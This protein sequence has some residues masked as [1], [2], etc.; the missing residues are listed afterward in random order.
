MYYRLGTLG[1]LLDSIMLKYDN[2][3]TPLQREREREREHL[4]VSF[5]CIYVYILSH[6]LTHDA[7]CSI[8]HTSMQQRGIN[9]QF[10]SLK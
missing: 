8:I 4:A 1:V 10:K 9:H 5:I 3:S 7:V 2:F 6:I